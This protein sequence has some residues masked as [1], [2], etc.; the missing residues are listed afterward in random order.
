MLNKKESNRFLDIVQNLKKL[1]PGQLDKLNIELKKGKL[2]RNFKKEFLMH[3]VEKI[4]KKERIFI[5][6][7]SN[8]ILRVPGA[9][10]LLTAKLIEE[11][12]HDEV[13]VSGGVTANDFIFLILV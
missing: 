10:N 6:L 11:I 3:F 1:K 7:K 9:Y 5:K 12:G 4:V 2:K 13:Y 8:K